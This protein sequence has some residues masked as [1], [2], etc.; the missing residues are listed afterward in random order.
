MQALTHWL[1]WTWAALALL[2]S[3]TIIRNRRRKVRREMER[4][5]WELCQSVNREME[6]RGA[7]GDGFRER[8]RSSPRG[9]FRGG[10]L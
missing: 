10:S 7:T 2:G 3:L 8:I 5:R 9:F 4:Q 6:R 1:W